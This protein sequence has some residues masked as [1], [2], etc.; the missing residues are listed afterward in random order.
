MLIKE[1]QEICHKESKVV[2]TSQQLEQNSCN[3]Y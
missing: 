3:T 1:V 2:E